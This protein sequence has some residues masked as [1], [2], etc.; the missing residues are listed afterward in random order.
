MFVIKNLNLLV[1]W[2]QLLIKTD[3]GLRLVP[4]LYA[5]PA[6]KVNDEYKNPGS[7]SREPLGRIPFMW[8]QSLYII[9][10]LLQEVC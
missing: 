10:R 2:I 1:F 3:D 7:Q 5:V 6:S 4:E 8:A 9:G